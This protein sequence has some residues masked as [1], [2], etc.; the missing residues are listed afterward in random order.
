MP[1]AFIW[2]H[3]D[4]KLEPKLIEWLDEAEEHAGVRGNLFVRKGN[5]QTTFMETYSDVTSATIKRIERLASGNP[6]FANIERRCESFQ[7]VDKL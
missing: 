6:L 1:D 2:Y 3:A 4:E 5:E 7:R